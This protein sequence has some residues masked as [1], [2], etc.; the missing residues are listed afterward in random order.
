MRQIA[1]LDDRQLDALGS[2]FGQRQRRLAVQRV[3]AKAAD[4]HGYISGLCH[5]EFSVV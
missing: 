4:D 1:D 5:W 3:L 2:L